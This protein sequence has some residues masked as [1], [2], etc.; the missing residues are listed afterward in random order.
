L[1]PA[2]RLALTPIAARIR[3]D[4]RRR[5]R[6]QLAG[7]PLFELTRSVRDLAKG[8]RERPVVA[9]RWSGDPIGELL[10]WI[11][12]LTWGTAATLGLRARLVAVAERGSAS[13]YAGVAGG[14]V[15][16]GADT[17][18]PLPLGD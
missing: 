17:A 7:Q 11:P 16:G 18:P 5:K 2:V 15:G 4:R 3:E 9:P 8:D 10:Y 6:A 1:A 13:R 14:R 12:F